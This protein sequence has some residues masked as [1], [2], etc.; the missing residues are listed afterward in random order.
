MGRLIDDLAEEENK[1][2]PLWFSGV[3]DRHSGQ[4]INAI[5]GRRTT[6]HQAA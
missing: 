4:V 1:D 3:I 5:M 2:A 6:Y